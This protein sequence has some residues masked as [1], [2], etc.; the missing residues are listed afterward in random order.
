MKPF[1][2][3]VLQEKLHPLGSNRTAMD[4]VCVLITDDKLARCYLRAKARKVC[5]A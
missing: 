3:E 1:T 2:R 5:V 4:T